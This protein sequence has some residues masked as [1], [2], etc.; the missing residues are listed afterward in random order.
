MNENSVGV[1]TRDIANLIYNLVQ[2]FSCYDWRKQTRILIHNTITTP[3]STGHS[4][5]QIKGRFRLT[6]IRYR[7]YGSIHNI[8]NLHQYRIGMSTSQ[9]RNSV[10]NHVPTNTRNKRIECSHIRIGYPDT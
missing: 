6:N 10:I 5:I 4:G 1:E 7:S 8:I 3:G 9:C 2:A